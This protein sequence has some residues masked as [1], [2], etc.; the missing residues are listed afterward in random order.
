M[1]SLLMDYICLS[2]QAVTQQLI[3]AKLATILR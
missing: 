1:Q 3:L 2:K